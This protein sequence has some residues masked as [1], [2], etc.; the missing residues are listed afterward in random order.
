MF[1]RTSAV[2]YLLSG[3]KPVSHTELELKSLILGNPLDDKLRIELEQRLADTEPGGIDSELLRRERMI[4]DALDRGESI[5]GQIQEYKQ[6]RITQSN[7]FWD[8]RGCLNHLFRPF[9][10]WLVHCNPSRAFALNVA[11]ENKLHK[12]VDIHCLPVEILRGKQPDAAYE[13]KN[14]IID[15]VRRYRGPSGREPTLNDDEIGIVMLAGY[16]RQAP[17]RNTG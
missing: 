15:F 10:L 13:I 12:K 5:D 9:S 8:M 4:A 2:D 11:L 17:T 14:G 7:Y 1:Y 6:F 3:L 16:S